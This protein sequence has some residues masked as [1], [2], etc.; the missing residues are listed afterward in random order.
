MKTEVG[1]GTNREP[2]SV[3]RPNT[4]SAELLGR[5]GLYSVNYDYSLGRFVSL[6]V[7]FSYW[8]L[9]TAATSTSVGSINITSPATSDTFTIIP[10]YTNIYFLSDRNRPYV[11]LG[12]D[13]VSTTST[14][15]SNSTLSAV[16]GSGT[17]PVIGAGYE[18][19]G[20]GGFLFRGATYVL[21]GSKTQQITGGASFGA[22]F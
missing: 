7:G 9:S 8:S 19:R 1:T 6:G 3:R 17:L 18:F 16:S 20:D 15:G 11:S 4:L 5:G 14:N 22:A 2:V 21:A 12:V 10:V 13:I